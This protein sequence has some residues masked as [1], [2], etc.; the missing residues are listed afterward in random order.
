[1]ELCGGVRGVFDTCNFEGLMGEASVQ[2]AE[3]L[4]SAIAQVTI[5]TALRKP[6]EADVYMQAGFGVMWAG[7]HGD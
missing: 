3:E 7:L 4:L 5:A 6:A 1:M 2:F